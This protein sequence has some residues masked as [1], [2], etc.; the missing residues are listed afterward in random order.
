MERVNNWRKNNPEKRKAQRKRER[1]RKFCKKYNINYEEYI[2]DRES[3]KI[4]LGLRAYKLTDEEKQIRKLIENAKDRAKK[5]N[6]P[7]DLKPEDIILLDKCPYLDI[8]LNRINTKTYSP[9]NTTIDRII[10]ELGYVNGNI[11]MLSMLA[12][13][14][15]S[16]ATLEELLAFAQ[17][18]IKI[19]A[20]PSK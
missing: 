2:A 10:P 4:S 1:D 3:V 14:M 7:F 13:T 20:P 15:K 5:Y 11:R 19:H 17:N 6:L 9:N 8:P 16:N 18:V 12:N